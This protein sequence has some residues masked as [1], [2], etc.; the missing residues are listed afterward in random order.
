[1][2]WGLCTKMRQIYCLI[3]GRVTLI[4]IQQHPSVLETATMIQCWHAVAGLWG[5]PMTKKSYRKLLQRRTWNGVQQYNVIELSDYGCVRILAFQGYSSGTKQRI[6]ALQTSG[7][8]RILC[9][10][11]RIYMMVSDHQLIYSVATTR[12]CN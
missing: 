1:M 2:F 9:Q 10:C 7:N 4:H 11:I 5:L 8:V 12:Q 3:I 6:E